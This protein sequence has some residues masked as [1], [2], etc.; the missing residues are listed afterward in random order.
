MRSPH[1]LRG[2]DRCRRECQPRPPPPALRR[3]PPSAPRELR[4]PRGRTP[5]THRQDASARDGWS[6]SAARA[7]P[8]SRDGGGSSPSRRPADAAEPGARA[9]LLVRSIAFLVYSFAQRLQGPVVQHLRRILAAAHQAPDLI[10]AQTGVPQRDGVPLALRK[11]RHLV[12]QRAVLDAVLSLSGRVLLGH[13]L[14]LDG[15]PQ[16]CAAPVRAEMIE[17]RVARDPKQPRRRRGVAGLETRVGLVGVHEDL[18]CDVL[19]VRGRADLRPDVGVDATEVFPVEAFERRPGGEQGRFMVLG[20]TT[21][22]AN[23]RPAGTVTRLM[24]KGGA[25][26]SRPGAEDGVRLALPAPLYRRVVVHGPDPD[27]PA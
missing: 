17:R 11:L 8:R 9:L 3:R 15:A 10:K 4:E 1:L 7:R 5:R 21:E 24:A 26:L 6:A 25:D 18:R 27:S 19:G 16:A 13:R 23:A 14:V 20:Y 22:L 2:P 12:Q